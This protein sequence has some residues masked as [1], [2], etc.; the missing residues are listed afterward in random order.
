LEAAEFFNTVADNHRTVDIKVTEYLKKSKTWKLLHQGIRKP[1]SYLE[2][3]SISVV[4]VGTGLYNG[5]M[6][7]GNHRFLLADGTVTHNSG[8]THSMMGPRN[9]TNQEGIIPRM[10]HDL[11]KAADI[12]KDTTHFTIQCSYVEIYLEKVRDLLNP[13]LDNLKLREVVS[14]RYGKGSKIPKAS[15]SYVYIEGCTVCTVRNIKDMFKVMR[16]GESNRMTASTEM[17]DRSSRSHSVFV[18]NVVQTSITKQT[19]KSSKLFL[20]DLAGSENVGR[21]KASGLTLEQAA[22][23]NKSLSALSLVISSLVDK[24]K[25][26]IPYRDSKLTRLLTDSL[27]GNSK[28]VLLLALSPSFDS[29]RESYSTLSFGVRA[30]RVENC[31]RINEDISIATYKRLVSQLRKELV[32]WKSKYGVLRSKYGVLR[33][34]YDQVVDLLGQN[35]IELPEGLTLSPEEVF[36]EPSDEPLDE[37][38]DEPD[39]QPFRP[40][41]DRSPVSES[42]SFAATDSGSPSTDAQSAIQTSEASTQ[43]SVPAEGAGGDAGTTAPARAGPKSVP[44]TVFHGKD[45]DRFALH[46]LH[47][48][49]SSGISE[50]HSVHSLIEN[51]Q[52]EE[53]ITYGPDDVVEVTIGDAVD[54]AEEKLSAEEAETLR[55]MKEMMAQSEADDVSTS[56]TP[57][58][59]LVFDTPRNR[60]G[61]VVS[62][63][64]LEDLSMFQTGNLVV[65]GTDSM[66]VFEKF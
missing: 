29:L 50:T 63:E 18:V 7:D 61:S 5:F 66:F 48:R 25:A 53:S 14:K 12:Q 23:I 65:W 38:S 26:H 8:K 10:M 57:V 17:N 2:H 36:N 37:L 51:V 44:F 43:T 15:K 41:E 16:K 42:G 13:K 60:S 52:D 47:A 40:A 33:T 6:L 59:E 45:H 19:R 62:Q 9:I 27:G 55:T 56:S 21:S 1:V 4:P 22:Q 46:A 28:T 30:K 32:A 35:N 49:I 20:V 39:N 58:P 3:T 24:K 64:L 11:F 54:E 31:A 34:K